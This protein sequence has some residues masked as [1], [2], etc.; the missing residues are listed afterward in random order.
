MQQSHLSLSDSEP[1]IGASRLNLSN[2]APDLPLPSPDLPLPS[3]IEPPPPVYNT[4]D[5][6][7]AQQEAT[8][9]YIHHLEER[10][11][12]LEARTWWS[13]LVTQIK[14]WFGR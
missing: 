1:S 4:L 11:I 9:S 5:I 14:S 13:M 6:L 3:R 8:I 10:I 2:P 12:A 7:S